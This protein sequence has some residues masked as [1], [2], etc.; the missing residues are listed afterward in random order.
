MVRDPRR[1]RA[2]D[3]RPVLVFI[4][5]SGDSGRSWSSIIERLPQYTCVALDLP[6]HG[7]Q[8]EHPGPHAISVRDYAC[9]VHTLLA[10]RDKYASPTLDG[11]GVCLVGHSLG[12]AIAMRLA[13]DHPALV[14]HLVLVGAGARLRVLPS[15]LD[16]ARTHPDQ[17]MRKL[18]TLGFA[19]NHETQAPQYFDALL[20]TA[21]DAL[22]RDLSACNDFDMMAE[23]GRVTPPTLIVVGEADRLTPPKYAAFLHD[24]IAGAELLTV[25]NAGHYV[26]AEAPDALADALC[27]WLSRHA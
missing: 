14:T 13:V 3:P 5:G 20:P 15:L 7:A 26:P 16:E 6:G 18:V 2:T 10:E 25:P 4:H 23:L 8:L 21:P 12:S 19:P 11:Y 27:A 1:T 22:H 17:A 9:T 24:H